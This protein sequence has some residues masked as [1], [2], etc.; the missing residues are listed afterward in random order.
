MKNRGMNMGTFRGTVAAVLA[1][2]MVF[3]AVFVSKPAAAQAKELA[4]SVIT[5]NTDKVT[6]RT[7]EVAEDVL[8]VR[9]LNADYTLD[10]SSNNKKLKYQRTFTRKDTEINAV[11]IKIS[12]YSSK[13]DTYKL[14]LKVKNGEK[15]VDEQRITVN[16]TSKDPVEVIKFAGEKLSH[17]SH[18]L[19][20]Q[21]YVTDSKSG[22]L[23]V[24]MSKGYSLDAIMIGKN[25]ILSDDN[26]T[27][28]VYT[29]A[30]NNTVIALGNV[31]DTLII[32]DD[33]MERTTKSMTA[34]TVIRIEYTE[35]A[36]GSSGY[37]NYYLSNLVNSEN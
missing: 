3:A 7:N 34:V 15:V 31:P 35:K 14:T 23:S 30:K 18:K 32:R 16:S 8:D 28:M 20:T 13:K 1:G 22:K 9:L 37:V 6:I 24:R 26:S 29:S 27:Q 33:D 4:S 5:V 21:G 10:I 25:R 17:D 19:G 36:T 11:R 2:A 12:L